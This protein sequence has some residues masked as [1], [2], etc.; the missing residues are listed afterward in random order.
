MNE[1]LEIIVDADVK[2]L[3]D[4]LEQGE[5]ALDDLGDKSK[6]SSKELQEAISSAAKATATAMAGVTAALAAGAT[7]MVGLAEST[8]EYRTGQEKL[9][10]AFKTAGSNAT[11]AYKTYSKLNSVIG[12]SD[13]AVE[14]ASHLAKLTTN[15][16]ELEQWTKV[17][18]GVYATF[19]DSL[20]IEGLTEAA[21]E[22]A[23]VGQVTGSLADALNWAGVNEDWFNEQLA[24]CTTEQERQSLILST[25]NGLY[26]E[27]AATYEKSAADIIA[28]NE[29]TERWNNSLA[30]IGGAMEPVATGLKNLG[31]SLLEDLEE[32]ARKAAEAFEEDIL[33]AIEGVI[34]FVSE[35]GDVIATAL[36]VA[37]TA[38]V[39]YQ[40]SVL[41]AELAT[42]G[43]TI[44]TIAQE[45]AQM[46]L[47]VV[48][49]AN[50]IGLVLTAIAAVTAG[51]VA[52]NAIT[53]EANEKQDA[54]NEEERALVDSIDD[55]TESIQARKTA[56]EES[57]S[58][59]MGEAEHAK[60][61]VEELTKLADANGVVA[62]ANQT[63]A[64]FILNELNDAYGTEYTMVDGV[65]QKYD[66][67]ISSIY[68]VIEAKTASML[69]DNKEQG[70]VE[71]IQ[72]QSSAL[73][74]VVAA[75]KDYEAQ[76]GVVEQSEKEY[77]QF[78]KQYQEKLADAKNQGDYRALASDV[79]KLSQLEANTTREKEL[80]D[81][82]EQK[83]DE[84]AQN[85]GDYTNTINDYENASAAILE[86]N[87]KEAIGIL[88]N[89][90][91]AYF[92]YSEDVSQATQDA[93]DAL[94]EEA[95]EAGIAAAEI[96]TN[97][98]NGVEGYTEEMVKESEQAYEDALDAWANA[99]SDAEDIGEDVGSGLANGM[100]NKVP[101]LIQKAKS[102]ISRIWSAMRSE[103]ESNSPSKKTM[104]LGGDIGAG[105]EIGIDKS[106]D[107][108]LKSAEE[109]T[110]TAFLPIEAS[111][112]G[113]SWNGFDTLTSGTSLMP[114][115]QT[116]NL[117][118]INSI[119]TDR[120][121]ESQ[122][123]SNTPIILQV[124]G[125][126][127]AQISV[128]SINQL[129]RQVGSL[130]LKLV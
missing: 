114:N 33:P 63:R 50:P 115:L 80:L 66:E 26:G 30:N 16:K 15:E 59:I 19:G 72:G 128:D 27:A 130:P 124:D 121:Y 99:Y 104:R 7:A 2:G 101:T 24:S 105:L 113:V 102:L 51:I 52:W 18:T 45:A 53:D 76:L 67:L 89:K 116:T 126:T 56:F 71:A 25:L 4:G 127:F 119:N 64:Q 92:E 21:N 73:Q 11:T 117:A 109:L 90:S 28:A 13:V 78:Y 120:W 14:A 46:A 108:V 86:G 68:E 62:E 17:C 60:N 47:N 107:K 29:A 48:M 10:T 54:L 32:P 100:E 83:Y 123:N 85:Y 84:A 97:F 74:T 118:N 75:Q 61:L 88:S 69:L 39:G 70:Y 31:S 23:K 38:F 57:A 58:S 40:A 3:K 106:T 5:K 55:T 42:K 79:Q 94:Y 36:T 129:T 44:A 12:D 8:R 37:A 96:K 112:Q 65:I 20:P 9:N 49:N 110:R 91:N 87:Y 122:M 82:K 103:A 41:A 22:T 125:R 111:V 93:I 34:N 35:N 43:W 6:K 77:E 81:E 95:V 98:E 1:K